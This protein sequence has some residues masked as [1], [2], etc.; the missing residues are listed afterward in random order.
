MTVVSRSGLARQPVAKCR[1]SKTIRALLAEGAA[2]FEKARISYGHGTN[3]AWDEAAWL[4][5]Y[6]LRLPLGDLDS[7]LDRV[8]SESQ[9]KAA[10]SLLERRVRTRAPAAYLTREAWLGEKRFYVDE[11]VIVP[12][13][14]IAEL[15]RKREDPFALGRARFAPKRVLDLCTGSGCLAILLALRFPSA[16]VDAVDLSADALAVARKNVAAY[17]LRRR[18][19]LVQS[20]LFE[21]L[22]ARTYDLI[23]SNPPYVNASSMRSLPEEYRK[24]PR[25]ALASGT[26]GLD[27]TRIILAQA[28]AHLKTGAALVVEVG[29]NRTALEKSFPHLKFKWPNTRAGKG[30]VFALRRDEI[31]APEAK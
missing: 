29:H 12:R 18:I 4:I 31:R 27:H 5:L 13:S 10:R 20:D 28:R 21:A 3:N 26:D 19:R 25:M 1:D 23:V 17:G 16:E 30:F 14:F 15:L 9:C 6:A 7:C 22:G 2:M 24:E 8:L 11:R